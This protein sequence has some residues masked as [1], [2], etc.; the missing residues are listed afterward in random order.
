MEQFTFL[1]FGYLGVILAASGAV[2]AL[3]NTTLMT[4]AFA[5]CSTF[6]KGTTCE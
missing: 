4:H 6:V 2:G 3:P 1:P 5:L